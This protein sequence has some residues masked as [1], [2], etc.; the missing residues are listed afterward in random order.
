MVSGF[1]DTKRYEIHQKFDLFLANIMH[2]NYPQKRYSIFSYDL[3]QTFLRQ[4]PQ[5]LRVCEFNFIIQ[6][7]IYSSALPRPNTIFFQRV[8]QHPGIC[9]LSRSQR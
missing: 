9:S 3:V 7:G 2:K 8:G 4:N 6:L 5:G 1:F